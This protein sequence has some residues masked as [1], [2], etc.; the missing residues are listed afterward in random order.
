MSKYQKNPGVYSTLE[1]INS[2]FKPYAY[3]EVYNILI[4]VMNYSWRRGNSRPP[5]FLIQKLEEDRIVFKKFRTTN[6][7]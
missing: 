4:N 2:I 3:Y 6:T 7:S 5:K 1:S